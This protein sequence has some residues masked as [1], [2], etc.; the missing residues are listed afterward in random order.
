MDANDHDIDLDGLSRLGS[1][2]SD[3]T[4]RR[5]LVALARGPGY[6]AELAVELDES[7]QNISNHLACLRGCGLV[8][9]FPEGR[10]MRY[11]LVDAGLA[12]A[13]RDL[14]ELTVAVD[15]QHAHRPERSA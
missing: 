13:L 9:A 1:A 10:R 14:V 3:H 11:E 4:R 6:P 8:V 2:L 5:L 12:T 15:P 7:R